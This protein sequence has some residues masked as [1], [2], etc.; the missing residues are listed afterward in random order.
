MRL[1]ATFL[2]LHGFDL[3]TAAAAAAGLLGFGLVQVQLPQA[4]EQSYG[5]YT[6]LTG[7]HILPLL[8][9]PIVGFVLTGEAPQLERQ[10]SRRM[11]AARGGLLL[12]CT[13]VALCALLPA[14]LVVDVDHAVQVTA[15]NTLFVLGASAVLSVWFDRTWAWFPVF[16]IGT[17][18]LIAA[19]QST[20]SAIAVI[21]R[22]P[23]DTTICIIVWLVGLV[24]YVV[25]G[26]NKRSQE[27]GVD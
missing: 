9:A 23:G 26:A 6:R 20:L 5:D 25:K 17:A 14:S 1:A 2:R 22:T 13:A 3:F 7:F 8:L 24:H 10:A 4:V 11:Q 15:E 16:A 21:D 12:G 19:D 27:T 18:G